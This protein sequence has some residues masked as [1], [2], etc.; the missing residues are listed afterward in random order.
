MF[1]GLCKAC[2]GF[3]RKGMLVKDVPGIGIYHQHCYDREQRKISANVV[4]PE[5]TE[6]EGNG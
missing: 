3:L 6:G 1:I 5:T 2:E 4:K